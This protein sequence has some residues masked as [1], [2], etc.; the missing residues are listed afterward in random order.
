MRP[1]PGETSFR[2]V[3][4][5]QGRRPTSPDVAGGSTDAERVRDLK[6]SRLSRIAR[7]SRRSCGIF[8]FSKKKI[9]VKR[10]R[11][12]RKKK[13]EEEE[14]LERTRGASQ[15]ASP[16]DDGSRRTAQKSRKVSFRTVLQW[17][18]DLSSCHRPFEGEQDQLDQDPAEGT[19]QTKGGK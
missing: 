12:S 11:G 7:R 13:G 9:R 1:P 2:T 4:R 19:G 18:R 6:K 10:S 5:R 8:Y 15:P 3:Y 16:N 17:S 14:R